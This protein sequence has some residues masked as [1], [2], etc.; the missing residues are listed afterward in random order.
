MSGTALAPA[1][2]ARVAASPTWRWAALAALLITSGCAGVSDRVVLLPQPGGTPSAVLVSATPAA[3]GQS[4]LLDKPYATAELQR[5]SLRAGQTTAEAVQQDYGPLLA[6]QAPRPQRFTVQF[7]ANGSRLNPDAAAVLDQ[8]R[9]ALGRLVAP[10]VIVIGHTDRVGSVEANDKLSVQRAEAVRE[11]LVAAGFARE[12]I[13]VFGR[14]E[15][16][17]AVPTADE[18]AE[19]RNRRVEIKLR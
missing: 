11:I 5:G 8:V 16:E 2:G 9:Q 18:V 10:E 4:L 15:R 14:G 19:P 7:E 12:V 3:G 13:T 17:P 1:G 6:L